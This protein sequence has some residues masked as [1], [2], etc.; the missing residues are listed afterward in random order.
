IA[1]PS[2]EVIG[3]EAAGALAPFHNRAF[4]GETLIYEQA[5]IDANGRNRWI[6]GRMVPDHRFDGTIQGVY[7]VGHDI[8]DLKEAQDALAARE[9]QLRVIIE[10]APDPTALICRS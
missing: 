8:T 7:V 4:A 9:L 3:T 1:K 2:E 6:R 10:G 5:L